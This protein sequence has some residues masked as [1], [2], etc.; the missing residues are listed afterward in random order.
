MNKIA[1]KTNKILLF[2]SVFVRSL[3]F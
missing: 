1:D 2:Q 3:G